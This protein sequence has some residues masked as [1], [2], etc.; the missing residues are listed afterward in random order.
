MLKHNIVNQLDSN[1]KQKLK[2][3]TKKQK[4][5]SFPKD[6]LPKTHWGDPAHGVKLAEPRS[7]NMPLIYKKLFAR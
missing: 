4:N 6:F 7:K 2:K 5:P 3:Q 1:I